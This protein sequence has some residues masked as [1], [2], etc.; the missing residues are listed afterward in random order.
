MCLLYIWTQSFTTQQVAIQ[1]LTFKSIELIFSLYLGS[2]CYFM[3]N[4]LYMGLKVQYSY[5]A[6]AY[7]IHF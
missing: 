1:L 2:F 3:H 7:A 5:L 6:I 4:F